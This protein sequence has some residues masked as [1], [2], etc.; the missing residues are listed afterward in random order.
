M[1]SQITTMNQSRIWCLNFRQTDL[2][3]T[4]TFPAPEYRLKKNQIGL[5]SKIIK[6]LKQY[7]EA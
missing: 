5:L 3:E 4:P 1:F 2:L 7:E 6:Y